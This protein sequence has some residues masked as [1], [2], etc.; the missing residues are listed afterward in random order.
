VTVAI[1]RQP[2]A[3]A[4]APRTVF[5]IFALALT[6]AL[7]IV[8]YVVP[9]NANDFL[10]HLLY[11][12]THPFSITF[13]RQWLEE[14]TSSSDWRPLQ[15]TIAHL[16]YFVARGH[17]HL[18]FK[19][20]LSISVAATGWLLWRLM[21]VQNWREA[22]A[23][24]T[25][26]MILFA[27]HSFAG[28]VEAVY[29]YGVEI[30]LVICELYV[31][32][33]LILGRPSYA[34]GAAVIAVSVFA[35][36]L[37]E[38]GGL[39]GMTYLVGAALRMPGGSRRAAAMVFALYLAIVVLRFGY[40]TSPLSLIQRSGTHSVGE[41]TFDFVA[42]ALNV[43]ISDPRFGKFRTFP[44][45]F[46]W[47]HPWAIVTVASSLTTLA[48]ILAWAARTFDR[49]TMSTELKVGVILVA[50]VAGSMMFGPFSQKD[51]IPIM[52]LPAYALV[53]FYAIRWLLAQ[54]AGAIAGAA[55][56]AGFILFAG[57]SIRTAGLFYYMH[58][59]AYD[60]YDEWALVGE[61]HARFHEYPRLVGMPILERLRAEATQRRFTYTDYLMP[62]W[63]PY[64]LRG[65]GC[66]EFCGKYD[67]Q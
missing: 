19:G 56:V 11:F 29:P 6:G 4:L 51:Y 31:L 46:V 33:V 13:I 53:T 14:R 61:R 64:W 63:A 34:S 18:V 21:L 54:R 65:R 17:E 25:G 9:L 59:T 22:V 35:I 47:G 20:L 48:V 5:L 1:D 57:W 58:R 67:K 62:E 2:V 39:V 7:A 49:K 3:S 26:F 12:E 60:Y 44:Q 15:Y 27:H 24:M 50:M 32:G 28:A 55:L 23:A 30:I 45:A 36:L 16:L 10:Q 40:L 38:K 52:A 66:P 8:V 42:P 41:N 37:N 43:L